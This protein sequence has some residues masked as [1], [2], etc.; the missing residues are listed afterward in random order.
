[1]Q[2]GDRYIGR[3][4]IESRFVGEIVDRATVGN[5]PPSFQPS[6]AAPGSPGQST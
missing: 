5:T 1:M 4:I 2:I 3:S 6:P